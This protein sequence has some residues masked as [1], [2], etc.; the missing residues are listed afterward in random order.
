MPNVLQ[1]EKTQHIEFVASPALDLLN[2][3]YFTY[4]AGQLE[5]V[6]DWPAR[7]RDHMRP[8][9]REELD[10]LFSY[11]RSQPG[12]MGALNDTLFFHREAWDSVDAL[13]RFVRD[14]PADG[15]PEPS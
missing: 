11:P 6:G 8:A 1:R 3:M 7:T 4:L 2:C 15:T 12:V 9:V 13:T 14:L 10:L 5:G